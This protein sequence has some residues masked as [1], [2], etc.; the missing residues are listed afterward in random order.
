[1]INSY[2]KEYLADVFG[3]ES[4]LEMEY[5]T[6]F[7]KFFM[8][9]IRGSEKGSKKRYAGLVVDDAGKQRSYL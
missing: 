4:R 1:M 2:W 6:H 3:I 5:E 8:P 9:T 7:S